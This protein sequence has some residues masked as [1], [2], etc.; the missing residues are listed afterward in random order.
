MTEH[1]RE[2]PIQKRPEVVRE[3]PQR[4]PSRLQRLQSAL[5]AVVMVL[6]SAGVVAVVLG[7][8]SKHRGPSA[9][10]TASM[11]T[12]SRAS[13]TTS[14]APE[15]G[16]LAAVSSYWQAI[17]HHAFGVAY[18][19]LAPGAVPQTEAEWAAGEQRTGIQSARFAGLAGRSTAATTTVRVLSLVTRDVRYGCRSWTGNYLMVSRGGHWL[20]ARA[21][22]TPAPCPIS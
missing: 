21:D 18:S 12:P 22:I 19:L 4:R 10:S 7:T 15:D 2:A 5:T 11:T 1:P 14:I 3:T 17:D 13:T 8:G 20:I 16:A 9:S 6:V